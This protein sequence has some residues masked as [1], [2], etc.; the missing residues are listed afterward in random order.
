MIKNV[1]YAVFLFV[2][3][4]LLQVLILNN[5]HFFNL[6]TP[7]LYIYYILKLP[8]RVSRSWVVFLSFLIGLIVDW[9]SNTGGLHAASCTLL[10]LARYPLLKLFSNED[11]PE[12]VSP[13]VRSFGVGPFFRLVCLFVLTHHITLFTIESFTFFDPLFLILRILTSSVLTIL[14]IYVLESFNIGAVK[15]GE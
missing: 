15:S 7:F 5:I 3:L 11:I 2:F 12:D 9:L 4:V 10:G 8:I 1:V 14:L 13:A 6:A